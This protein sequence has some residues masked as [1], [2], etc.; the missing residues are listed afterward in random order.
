MKNY[1]VTDYG[2]V[3]DGVTDDTRAIRNAIDH[4]R[5]S[6]GGRV[7][8]AAGTYLCGGIR[9]YSHTDLHLSSDATLLM[10]TDPGAFPIPD[11]IN[12]RYL[13]LYRRRKLSPP[14]PHGAVHGMYRCDGGI[15]VH[16]RPGFRLVLLGLRL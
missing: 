13:W 8:L 7:S 4:C 15:G 6:G 2:A 14:S 16:D 3:G 12:E 10:S 9:L 1:D 11:I 5:R